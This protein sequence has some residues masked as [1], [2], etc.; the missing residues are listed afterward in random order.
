[1]CRDLLLSHPDP[2]HLHIVRTARDPSDNLALSSRNAYLTVEGRQVA[3]TLF[4]A[5]KAAEAAW[6]EGRTKAECVQRAV[7]VVE[8]AKS[9][10]QSRQS[11]LT[12]KLDYVEF[13]DSA[14]FEVLEGQAKRTQ[15]TVILSGALW[16][17]NTRLIDNIILGDANRILG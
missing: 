10:L 3:P 9:E 2:E 6:K 7:D 5:L 4:A 15:D 16:V 11:Q 13:N 1:M 14:S 8:R 17:D 12:V